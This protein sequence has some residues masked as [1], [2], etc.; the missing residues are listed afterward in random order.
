MHRS[1]SQN[2]FRSTLLTGLCLLPFAAAAQAQRS[3]A[4]G[5]VPVQEWCADQ[6]V[7]MTKEKALKQH[8]TDTTATHYNSRLHTCFMTLETKSGRVQ[9]KLLLDAYAQRTYASYFAM[10]DKPAMTKCVLMPNSKEEKRCN[11]REEFDS[12]VDS[13]FEKAQ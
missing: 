2:V 8:E 10:Q 7:R 3:Q 9:T 13:Y 1:V 6:G 11:S 4:T 5:G 12:F